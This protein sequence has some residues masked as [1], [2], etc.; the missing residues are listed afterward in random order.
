[1]HI[2]HA[3]IE[4]IFFLKKSK[5]DTSPPC[6]SA[7]NLCPPN[8]GGG[9]WTQGCGQK[10][11]ALFEQKFV[12]N[13]LNFHLEAPKGKSWPFGGVL[14]ARRLF[15]LLSNDPELGPKFFPNLQKGVLQPGD[16]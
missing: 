5:I 4:N 15:D 16:H 3:I 8:G 14:G 9:R 2:K 13:S 6:P 1:M 12:K 10:G 7:G 11:V